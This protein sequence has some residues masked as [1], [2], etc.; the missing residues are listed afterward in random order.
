MESELL[1]LKS[2][3]SQ[4][5]KRNQKVENDKNWETSKIRILLICFITYIVAFTYMKISNL[6]SIYYS[7]LV[8][9]IGFYLSS[10]SI[11]LAKKIW[12]KIIEN[13]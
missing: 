5:E 13:K 6:S 2:R 11:P 10:L 1:E 12:I 4:I 8:P 9:V 3:I 7:A